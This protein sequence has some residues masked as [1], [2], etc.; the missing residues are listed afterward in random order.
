MVRLMTGEANSSA[1]VTARDLAARRG[2]RLVFEGL[3]L[4]AGPGEAITVTGPNGSGK[5]TLLRIIVGL[6]PSFKG[7]CQI[8]PN[9]PGTA[10]FAGHLDGLKSSLTVDE[11]LTFWAGLYGGARVAVDAAIDRLALNSVADMPADMLSAGW[12]RR[13]GLARLLISR[14]PLWVLDEPFT[15]LDSENVARLDSVLEDHC[16]GGGIVILATH[17]TSSFSA[18]HSLDMRSYTPAAPL[19]AEAAW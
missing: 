4:S 2:D 5:S 8:S 12:R 1:T 13:A 9:S 17:Q 3:N 15:A 6:L 10:C 11:N 19:I 18:Q 14:S 16:A 7:T